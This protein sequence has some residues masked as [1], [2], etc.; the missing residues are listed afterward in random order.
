MSLSIFFNPLD[1][2]FLSFSGDKHS[3]GSKLNKND[4]TLKN[5]QDNDIAILGVDEYRG[6][7]SGQKFNNAPELIR[8]ALYPLSGWKSNKNIIDLGN[9]RPG[10]TIEETHDRLRSVM[11]ILYENDITAVVLGGSQDLDFSQ[12]AAAEVLGKMVNFGSIDSKVDFAPEFDGQ[13]LD[14]S[15]LHKILIHEPSFLYNICNIGYQSYLVEHDLLELIDKMYFEG[16]RLGVIHED[17][18][19]IEPFIRHLDVLS[20]D[21]SS[22]R[23]QDAPGQADLQPFGLSPEQAC[24]LTWYAGHSAALKSLGIYG[25]QPKQDQQGITAK[26]IATMLWYFVEGHNHRVHVTPFDT[27]DY[28][29]FTVAFN[30]P[31]SEIVFYKNLSTEKWWMEIPLSKG[32]VKFKDH[33]FIPCS[34]NDYIKAGKGEVP[35]KWVLAQSRIS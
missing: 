25:Y 28:Q 22:I 7:R 33:K 1:D 15:H 3:F 10:E 18:K 23:G 31:V 17:I 11:E 19:E 20:F 6:L 21:I 27:N 32:Q 29:K 35:D 4:S 24:Q 26:L 13:S 12:Y 9:L 16:I 14:K 2:K 30:G 34:Y 8:R 5:W